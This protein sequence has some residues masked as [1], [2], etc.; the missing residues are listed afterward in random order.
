MGDIETDMRPGLPVH[1]RLT[2]ACLYVFDGARWQQRAN[3][4]F[5]AAIATLN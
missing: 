3:F 5:R 2:E 4:P 1:A